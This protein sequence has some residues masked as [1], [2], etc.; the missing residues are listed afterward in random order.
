MLKSTEFLGKIFEVGRNVLTYKLFYSFG[1]LSVK[2]SQNGSKC[3]Q[4]NTDQMQVATVTPVIQETEAEL[5]LVV[6]RSLHIVLLYGV[7]DI[8]S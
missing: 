2:D 4:R 6:E 8:V 7:V 3:Y 1:I 5:D